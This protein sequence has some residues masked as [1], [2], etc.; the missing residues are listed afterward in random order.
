MNTL[1]T[2][3]TA[4]RAHALPCAYSAMPAARTPQA[5]IF[6]IFFIYSPIAPS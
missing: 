5:N 4:L 1:T 2:H 6:T 3:C